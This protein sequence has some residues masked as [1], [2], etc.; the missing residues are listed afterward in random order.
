MADVL[1]EQAMR[2]L[3]RALVGRFGVEA[4]LEAAAAAAL[5][6]CEHPERVDQA[7]NPMGLLYRVGQSAARPAVRWESRRVR[8]ELAPEPEVAA[9]DPEIVDLVRALGALT[10]KQRVAILLVH[11]YGET[12]ESAAEVL[13]VTETAL[14]NYIHRGLKRLR[15]TLGDN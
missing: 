5:W 4:G 12:Y 3:R 13:G 1:T 11:A 10:P 15:E 8:L 9:F 6:A 7:R 14:N 2:R